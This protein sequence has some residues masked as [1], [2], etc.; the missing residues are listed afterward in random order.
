MPLITGECKKCHGRAVFNTGNLAKEEVEA[1]MAKS[2]FGE[3]AADGWHVEIGSKADY[4]DLD[5]SRS[6]GTIEG[7]REYNQV[8]LEAKLSSVMNR[9]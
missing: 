7:A 1:W 8:M 6:F 5:W 4:Y 3:C 9:T 2:E